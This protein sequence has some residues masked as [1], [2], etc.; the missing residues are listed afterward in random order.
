MPKIKPCKKHTD[1]MQLG[2]VILNSIQQTA[3]EHADG[4]RSCGREWSCTCAA[5]RMVK[6]CPEKDCKTL[7][8]SLAHG[9]S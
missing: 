4:D 6:A 5:C 1:R 2:I 3:M 9:L 8:Y 7:A